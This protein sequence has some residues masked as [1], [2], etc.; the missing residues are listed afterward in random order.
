MFDKYV[1]WGDAI[2][3]VRKDG[4]VAGFEFGVRIS[5]YRGLRLSMVEDFRISIDG[6]PV[7]RADIR[8]TVRGREYCLDEMETEY[9]DRWEFAEV[10]RIFVHRPGGLLPGRRYRLDVEELLRV[11]YSQDLSASFC[12]KQ[13]VVAA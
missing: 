13:R 10:A 8:F 4:M 12:S 9:D 3:N 5:Y 7:A 11:S 2:H 6:E 1:I